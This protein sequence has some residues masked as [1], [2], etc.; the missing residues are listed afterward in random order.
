MLPCQWHDI[1]QPQQFI[2]PIRNEHKNLRA[3][4]VLVSKDFN[5]IHKSNGAVLTIANI[6]KS[7]MLL[8]AEAKLEVLFYN[9]KSG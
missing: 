8:A 7:V 1:A 5:N 2:L 4:G 9:A 3:R 6:M